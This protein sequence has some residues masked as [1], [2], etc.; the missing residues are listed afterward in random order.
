MRTWVSNWLMLSL[1]GTCRER[2]LTGQSMHMSPGDDRV[3]TLK[4]S[5]MLAI[6]AARDRNSANY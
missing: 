1:P 2:F 3:G 5:S 4:R 6:V